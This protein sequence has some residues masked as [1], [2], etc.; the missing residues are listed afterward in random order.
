MA[1]ARLLWW[2][3]AGPDGAIRGDLGDVE[4]AGGPDG[5]CPGRRLDVEHVPGLAVGSGRPHPQAL[6][7]ADGE[8]VGALVLAHDGAGGVHDLARR[9]AQVAGQ[10]ALGVAVGDE[11]DVVAV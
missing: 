9:L 10:E 1:V 6:A 5:H 4:P 2:R 11:A 7:L 3:A 8:G